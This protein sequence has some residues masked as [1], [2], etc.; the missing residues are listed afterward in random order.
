[1][2]TIFVA[3]H[4]F[5]TILLGVALWRARIAPTWLAVGLAAS[6]PIH[7]A[8]VMTGIRPI[9][10]LGWGLT[11]AGFAWAAWRLAKLP[12]DDFDLPPIAR[13]RG[14]IGGWAHRRSAMRSPMPLALVLVAL[15]ACGGGPTASPVPTATA[16]VS[17]ATGA[18]AVPTNPPAT[19]IPRCLPQCWAGRLMTPGPL[20]GDYT[21]SNFFG[22]QFTV[23]VPE[24]WYGY[25]DSTGELAIGPEGSED[26]RLEFWIDVYA[27]SDPSGKKD[28][29][30][31]ATADGITA[32]FVAKP[33]ID[34]IERQPAMFGRLPAQSIEYQRKA[35]AATEDPDCPAEIQPCAVEFG[36]PEWG[37]AFSEGDAFHSRLVLLKASWGGQDHA[38]YAMFWAIGP[39]YDELIDEARA[40]VDGARLPE[41][42]RP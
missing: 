28:A 37:G 8:S 21:T 1:L 39:A 30:I 9:D 6:Q 22:G 29:S 34:V 24:G 25:E 4:L 23:T 5:G 36:Y 35:G 17:P 31:E 26:A 12:N 3:G 16:V 10:L 18:A 27:A 33:I 11:A 20:A 40:V 13:Q 14:T 32:W 7:L 38:V 19:P 15:A 41:G 42:V 2:G